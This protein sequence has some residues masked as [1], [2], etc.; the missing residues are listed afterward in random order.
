MTLVGSFLIGG[1]PQI[2]GDC[3]LSRRGFPTSKA[4]L[5]L[6]G[7]VDASSLATL[8]D[9]FNFPSGLVQ[10][11]VLCGN[12][13][14]LGWAGRARDAEPVVRKL[15]ERQL[16][17]PVSSKEEFDKCLDEIWPRSDRLSI[18]ITG[19]LRHSGNQ[20]GSFAY[21]NATHTDCPTY[22]FVGSTGSGSDVFRSIL[23]SRFEQ[24]ESSGG[25]L[26]DP[27][28]LMICGYLIANEVLNGLPVKQAFGGVYEVATNIEWQFKKLDDIKYVVWSLKRGG[29]GKLQRKLEQMAH[30]KYTNDLLLV[31]VLIQDGRWSNIVYPI[32]PIY[33]TVRDSEIAEASIPDFRSHFTV[34]VFQLEGINSQQCVGVFVEPVSTNGSDYL[35]VEVEGP[36]LKMEITDQFVT[37]IETV[38]NGPNTLKN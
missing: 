29:D 6:V 5:P 10:K 34:H 3:L 33:R 30:L 23:Y 9:R 27:K 14:V 36:Q 16:S 7:E 26:I 19:H 31:R 24:H 38:A 28:P 22:N 21:G 37:T 15:R 11:V 1:V 13:L 4:T 2:I 18:G 32:G 17:T 20:F 8:P 25:G 12:D 35:K